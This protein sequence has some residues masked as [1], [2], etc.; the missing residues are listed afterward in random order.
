M[1][2]PFF[3]L[4]ILVC[5]HSHAQ[6]A[7]PLIFNETIHDFGTID[8]KAGNAVFEFTF[9]NN[10]GRPINI[11]SVAASCGCTTPGWTKETVENGKKGFVKASFDPKGR[12]GFFNKTLSV[13]TNLNGPPIV[14]QI[15]GT[16]TNADMENDIGRFTVAN[17]SL[18]TRTREINFGKVFIN[19]P[20]STQEMPMFN[21]G[22]KT[23]R[24]DSINAPKYLKVELPDSIGAQQKA[25]MKVTYNAMLRNQYGFLSDKIVL[26]TNDEAMP[27][28]SY[29]VFAT[30]EEFFLPVS[31]ED[32]DKI[33]VMTIESEG[34]DFGSFNMGSTVEKSVKIRNTGK[35]EL[36]LRYIQPNCPCVTVKTD[37]EKAKTGEEIKVTI[38]WKSEGKHGTQHKAI[39]FYSSDPVHPVQRLSLLGDI[40]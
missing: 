27:R 8:E 37:K 17:G 26:V 12:P 13:N 4:L 38:A 39:T 5:T 11:V 32:A 21:S 3:L 24:I 31:S 9:T 33:P 16:V 29:P 19:K 14:L 2:I 10:S 36:V 34:I 23:I 40:K 28:K 18:N 15:K 25:V 30:V 20:A 7:E 35:K 22:S 1:K 6:Q